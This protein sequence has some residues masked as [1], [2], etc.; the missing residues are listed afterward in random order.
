MAM[1]SIYHK[2][3]YLRDI[4]QLDAHQPYFHFLDMKQD[5]ISQAPCT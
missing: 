1:Y 2:P 4:K 5:S 3:N